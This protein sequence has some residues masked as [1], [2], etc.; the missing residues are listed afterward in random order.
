MTFIFLIYSKYCVTSCGAV[1]VGFAITLGQDFLRILRFSPTIIIPPLLPIH[2]VSSGVA[3]VYKYS[4]SHRIEGF[5]LINSQNLVKY[6]QKCTEQDDY[7]VG[8]IN[9]S[10]L[11][12]AAH[13]W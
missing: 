3:A 6:I 1:H 7:D 12:A 5:S 9:C 4:S 8:N 10:G 13:L 2:C 11:G